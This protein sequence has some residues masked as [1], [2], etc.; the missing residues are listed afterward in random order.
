MQITVDMKED[1]CHKLQPR[2]GVLHA[3]YQSKQDFF[4]SRDDEF[5]FALKDSCQH[6]CKL[7]LHSYGESYALSAG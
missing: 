3:L 7:E 5:L 2:L 1:C 4:V 6:E